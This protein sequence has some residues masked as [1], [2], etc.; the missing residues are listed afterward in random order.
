[1]TASPLIS[2]AELAELT[3]LAASSSRPHLVIIDVQWTLGRTDGYE[4]YLQAHLPGAR[5]VD[6]DRELAAPASV[7][8]GRHPLPAR[9]DFEQTVRALGVTADSTI[10][11]Y[12]QSHSLSAAR[13]WWLLGN[14]GLEA[15]VL[16]GGLAAW[17]AAGHPVEAGEP[18]AIAPSELQ[19][20]WDQLATVTIDEAAAFSASGV[21]LDARAVERYRGEV[22]P[23][24][25]RAGHI[26]G[27]LSAPTTGNLDAAGAFLPAAQLRERFAALGVDD[28][29]PVATYCGSG[30][31][32][33][34]ELLALE[35]AGFRGALFPGSWS[36][37]SQDADRPLALG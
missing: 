9:D 37:W 24:D 28:A 30:V 21:L 26:P 3:E 1:M 23:I 11:V 35:L 10:V 8:L 7:A 12:D 29:T 2:A 6:L 32:A 15:R 14:A 31:T 5:H 18:A 16:D 33:A 19:I 27:A 4:R 25:P 20:S 36:Q 13:L 17:R 34:H 22:E